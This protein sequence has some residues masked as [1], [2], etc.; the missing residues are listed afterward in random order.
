MTP[1]GE[2]LVEATRRSGEWDR[3]P[4][5]RPQ[6]QISPEL[7]AALGRDPVARAARDA[8]APSHRRQYAAWIAVAKREETRAKRL[9]ESLDLLRRGEKLGIRN[10]EAGSASDRGFQRPCS[11][12]ATS[13]SPITSAP[14]PRAYRCAPPCATEGAFGVEVHAGDR[15]AS[16]DSRCRAP[17]W[18]R[19]DSRI[20]TGD[21]F[22]LGAKAARVGEN[23]DRGL[24]VQL[25]RPLRQRPARTRSSGA[26][27]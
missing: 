3:A 6:P 7:T 4:A 23:L 17:R 13:R 20:V 11:S 18:Q 22:G 14:L 10:A 16:G 15:K 5:P 19:T 8:L 24:I 27:P 21:G 1:T 12:S 26:E 2:Q 25:P 9:A